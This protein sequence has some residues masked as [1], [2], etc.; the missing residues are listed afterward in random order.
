MEMT[1]VS[2]ESEDGIIHLGDLHPATLVS[3]RALGGIF[4]RCPTTINR[5]VDRGEL[6]Q[7]IK[8]FGGHYWTVGSLTRHFEACLVEAQAEKREFDQKVSRLNP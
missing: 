6:P 7:P 5:A 2:P 8:L 3:V 4:G 1:E